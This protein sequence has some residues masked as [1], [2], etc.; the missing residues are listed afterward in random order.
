MSGLRGVAARAR[1][2]L[3]VVMRLLPLV[4]LFGCP[5]AQPDERCP[6]VPCPAGQVCTMEGDCVRLARP[7][8]GAFD[9][10]AAPDAGPICGNGVTEG[11][12][13]AMTAMRSRPTLAEL[14]ARPH[15]A[16]TGSA[17]SRQRTAIWASSTAALTARLHVVV[18]ASTTGA[19]PRQPP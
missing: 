9:A 3:T 18:S 16:V 6:T 19:R 14:T 7:D 17:G 13:L 2:W 10:G 4:L 11:T 15:A 1:A 5:M 8:A 12:R